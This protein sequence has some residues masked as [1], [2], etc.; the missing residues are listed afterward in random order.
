[1]GEMLINMLV[2]IN[3]SEY[4]W[5][6]LYGIFADGAN[7]II[8]VLSVYIMI[9]GKTSSMIYVSVIAVVVAMLLYTAFYASDFL[10]QYTIG[11]PIVTSQWVAVAMLMMLCK[12]TV[13]KNG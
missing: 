5:I 3:F 8:G 1:V 4:W 12:K 10:T 7:I 6:V 9:N 11:I 2:G 13:L